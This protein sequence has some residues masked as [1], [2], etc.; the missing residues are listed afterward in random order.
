ME[1]SGKRFIIFMVPVSLL[2]ILLNFG[3]R[4]NDQMQTADPH[5]LELGSYQE[6]SGGQ[7]TFYLP[8]AYQQVKTDTDEITLTGIITVR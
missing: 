3:C 6:Y 7:F 5:K 4:Q 1:K 2:L 8:Q